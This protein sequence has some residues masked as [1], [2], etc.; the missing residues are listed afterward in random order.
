MFP[1]FTE[2]TGGWLLAI[3]AGQG[4]FLKFVGPRK[5]I[6]LTWLLS[7]MWLI[8][9]PAEWYINVS[10]TAFLHVRVLLD[11]TIKNE[12]IWAV[13]APYSF[14]ELVRAILQVKPD[15]PVAPDFFGDEGEKKPQTTIDFARAK[16]LMEPYGFKGLETTVREALGT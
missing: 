8:T 10:D 11:A 12:R 5:F 2:S 1:G 16:A 7:F 14:G 3:A 6:G 4:E 9:L 15:A 13:E